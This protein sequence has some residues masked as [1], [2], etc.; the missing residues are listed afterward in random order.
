MKNL[1]TIEGSFSFEECNSN[2]GAPV[3]VFYITTNERE[4]YYSCLLNNEGHEGTIILRGLDILCRKNEKDTMLKRLSDIDKNGVD[5]CTDP[6][7][8]LIPPHTRNV[9]TQ[10]INKMGFKDEE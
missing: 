6:C 2:F 1:Q 10:A 5:Q 4:E 7:C 8:P 9:C 3:L